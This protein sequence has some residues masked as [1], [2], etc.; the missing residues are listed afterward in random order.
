MKD[1]LRKFEPSQFNIVLMTESGKYVAGR[2]G[3]SFS[4]SLLND[5]FML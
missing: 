4:F 5:N 3:E 1:A 2:F